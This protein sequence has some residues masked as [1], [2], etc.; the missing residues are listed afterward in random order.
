MLNEAPLPHRE[1]QF[2]TMRERNF[3]Q[4]DKVFLGLHGT[5]A[6]R[7]AQ[8]TMDRKMLLQLIRNATL[9]LR[10]AGHTLLIDPDL[11]AKHS[12]PS[13][14]GRSPTPPMARSYILN[15]SHPRQPGLHLPSA[16]ADW[17]G[18]SLDTLCP[19]RYTLIGATQI[20][21]EQQTDYQH[22]VIADVPILGRGLFLDGNVQLLAHGEQAYHERLALLPLLAHERPEQ[23]LILGG[24]DGCAAR[25]ALRDPRVQQVTLVELD[26]GVIDACAA[27]LGDLNRGSLRDTR[28]NIEIADARAF[29]RHAPLGDYAVVIVD[30]L[31]AYTSEDLALYNQVLADLAARIA[32]ST[33]VSLHGDL[34]NPPYWSALRLRAIAARHFAQVALHSAYV[35][36]YQSEWGFL[37]AGHTGEWADHLA[38][39]QI[40]QHAAALAAPLQTIVPELFPAALRLPPQLAEPAALIADNPF[41]LPED[42]YPETRWIGLFD[43]GQ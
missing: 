13:F 38:A 24:G 27:H 15:E 34:A 39:Q 30:F 19:G 3:V 16:A 4:H 1:S 32:P 20:I 33:L 2:A 36:C 26:A 14:T 6:V 37:L 23:V 22:L 9:R 7:H 8:L 18:L 10:Y 42:H 12:R 17:K 40:Q 25:E 11:A 21:V 5:F 43:D 35:G 28:V 31:D 29:L 41:Q